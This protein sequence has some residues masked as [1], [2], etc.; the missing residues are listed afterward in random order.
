[1]TAHTH[2]ITFI[3]LFCGIGTITLLA[4]KQAK[5]AYGIEYV[6]AAT[7]NGSEN[8]KLNGLSN[9]KFICGDCTAEFG[10]LAKKV[11]EIDVLI[12]DPP[13]KG[14]D[15]ALIKQIIKTAPKRMVYVS[16][17]PASLAR[18]T[19]LLGEF[20]YV[21]EWVTPVDMFPQTYHIETVT[22]FVLR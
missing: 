1:M 2:T 4:A 22:R 9:A 3:D 17:D 21:L 13:R 7:D 19:R 20:G 16:C 5:T 18:D 11:G 12:V 6:K 10:K 8:A 14:L 15:D